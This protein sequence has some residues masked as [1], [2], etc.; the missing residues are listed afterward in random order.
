MANSD[1]SRRWIADQIS[2]CYIRGIDFGTLTSK[3]PNMVWNVRDSWQVRGLFPVMILIDMVKA[4]SM[5]YLYFVFD[6]NESPFEACTVCNLR[7]YLKWYVRMNKLTF[8]LPGWISALPKLHI[9]TILHFYLPQTKLWE[10]NV[11][12]GVCYSVWGWGGN[13]Q[14][15]P[16][17]LP[18]PPRDMEPGYLPPTCAWDLGA[19]TPSPLLLTSGGHHWKP[20]QTWSLEDLPP[21]LPPVLTSS[22][23]HWNM[24]SWQAGGTHPT[25]MLSC[26][27]RQVNRKSTC[28]EE[29]FT[30]NEQIDVFEKSI[31]PINGITATT[32]KRYIKQDSHVWLTVHVA[33]VENLHKVCP[34]DHQDCHLVPC[35]WLFRYSHEYR[36]KILK[37]SPCTLTPLTLY[38][39]VAGFSPLLPEIYG[40]FLTRAKIP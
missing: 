34:G 30:H 15:A 38:G 7:I 25:G 35:L 17:Y 1:L 37:H 40:I 9:F 2:D 29:K 32:W 18:P 21:P 24:Y 28:P 33:Y 31:W 14:M 4:I 20:V 5:L 13:A 10:C 27:L 12:T 3:A 22:G 16:G 26:S 23:G 8:G 11:F 39:N 36:C 19:Y 6:W